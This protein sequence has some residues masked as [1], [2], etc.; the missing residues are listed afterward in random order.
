MK[1]WTLVCGIAAV[2]GSLYANTIGDVERFALAENREEAL[3]E[4]IA[5]T[6]DYYFYSCLHYQHEGDLARVDKLLKEWD[7]RRNHE[8][9]GF[10]E[11]RN[12]QALLRYGGDAKE[13]DATLRYVHIFYRRRWRTSR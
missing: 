5:G 10:R 4:L 13:K 11:I 6:D 9:A 7:D 2:A 8:P 3:S 1:K 12:R